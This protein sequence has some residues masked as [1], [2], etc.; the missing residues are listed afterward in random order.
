MMSQKV[1]LQRIKF[2]IQKPIRP[3]LSYLLFLWNKPDIATKKMLINR[4]GCFLKLVTS[5]V[6]DRFV[7]EYVPNK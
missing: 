6:T 4:K 1:L 3:T 2:I 7:K 5:L